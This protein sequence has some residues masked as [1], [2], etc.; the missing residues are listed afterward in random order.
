MAL[1]FPTA[2]SS[3]PRTTP[4][5]K[6]ANISTPTRCII[7]RRPAWW[8]PPASRRKLFAWPVTT[9]IIPCPTIRCWT[10][11]SSNA[12]ANRRKPSAKR[13][14]RRTSR[15]N[16]CRFDAGAAGS[17][18]VVFARGVFFQHLV[19]DLR[20]LFVRA[21]FAAR[22]RRGEAGDQLFPLRILVGGHQPAVRGLQ[23]GPER[24]A[25]GNLDPQH[26]AIHHVRQHLQQRAVVRSE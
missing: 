20:R 11:T 17:Q 16:C 21:D 8:R 15:L 13:R 19:V 10:S 7:C 25:L 24:R 22:H 2:A 3:W 6:S 26:L 1:I 23:R 12:A 18:R 14:R 5:T 9:A 4:W